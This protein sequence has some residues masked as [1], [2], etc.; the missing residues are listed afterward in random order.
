MKYSERLDL[1]NNWFNGSYSKTLYLQHKENYPCHLQLDSKYLY[2]SNLGELCVYERS[3]TGL[4][5]KEKIGKYEGSEITHLVKNDDILMGSKVNGEIFTHTEEGGLQAELFGRPFDIINSVDYNGEIAVV[6]SDK[7]TK[8]LAFSEEF[9][10]TTFNPLKFLK[11][12]FLEAKISPKGNEF[13]AV[14]Q[15]YGIHFSMIDIET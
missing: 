12:S 14:E 9:G 6:S 10:M 11:K 2:V 8:V 7:E 1:F 3:L 15:D 4:K 13:L 5:L